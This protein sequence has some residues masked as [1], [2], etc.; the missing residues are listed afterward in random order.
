MA[1]FNPSTAV[2]DCSSSRLLHLINLNES[3]S[4]E[5][6]PDDMVAM[7]D[8]QYRAPLAFDLSAVETGRREAK[9][10]DQSLTQGAAARIKTFEDL[11]FHPEPPLPLLKLTK[12]FFKQRTQTHKKDSAEWQLA[13]LFYLL[14]ILVSR[15][16]GANISALSAGELVDAIKWG[17]S[18]G[19][20]DEK[21][22]ALLVSARQFL[23]ASL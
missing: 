4:D 12:E 5:W 20:V 6:Q 10:R 17:S 3:N 22:K 2:S 16:R 15:M 18:R 11:F 13:Y 23:Q 8:H 21:T 9:A 7:L 1:K 14:S 19:W